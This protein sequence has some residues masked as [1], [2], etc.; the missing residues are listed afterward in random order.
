MTILQKQYLSESLPNHLSPQLY[1]FNPNSI[2]SITGQL[3][4]APSSVKKKFDMMKDTTF[5]NTVI[6]APTLIPSTENRTLDHLLTTKL[7]LASFNPKLI[8]SHYTCLPQNIVL[9]LISY[10]SRQRPT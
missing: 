4:S 10:A 1:L 5:R 6:L 7:S 8:S 3:T 2:V 9:N